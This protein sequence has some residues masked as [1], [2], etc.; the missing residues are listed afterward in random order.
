M[1][2][3]IFLLSVLMAVSCA[4]KVV[5]APDRL[6]SMEQMESIVYDLSLLQAAIQTD[7]SYFKEQSMTP[8]TY[9]YKKHEIDSLTYVQNDLYYASKPLEYEIIYRRVEKKLQALKETYDQE[10]AAASGVPEIN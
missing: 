8:L 7:R 5:P 9:V 4:H 1:K 10:A 3:T 6:L 2:K